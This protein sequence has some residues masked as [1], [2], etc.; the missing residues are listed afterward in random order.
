MNQ[1]ILEEKKQMLFD[2]INSDQYEP[3][4]FKEIA[5]ALQV[6]KSEKNELRMVLESL[7][8]DGKITIDN[9]GKYIILESNIKVFRNSGRGTGGHIYTRQCNERC[10]AWR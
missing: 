8:F 1:Q 9:K 10:N 4:K 6:P 3:L 2:F 7:I 5:A